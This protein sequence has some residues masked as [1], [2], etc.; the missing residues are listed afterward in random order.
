MASREE[1]LPFFT[2]RIRRQ[3][4]TSGLCVS[5]V[6]YIIHICLAHE[7]DDY[8]YKIFSVVISS[9]LA[10]TNVILAGKRDS[11]RHAT[12]SFSENVVV[13]GTSY[14]ILEVYNFA[15]G[16]GLNLVQ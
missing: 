7:E 9:A 8:Q 14:H 16:K 6:W 4:L 15:T 11:H 1:V 5:A 3:T 13:T 2:V 12:T 10:W